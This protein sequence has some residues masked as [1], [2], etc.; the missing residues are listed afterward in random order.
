MK[1]T[2]LTTV[3]HI[4]QCLKNRHSHN[5][6]FFFYTLYILLLFFYNYV[7]LIFHTSSYRFRTCTEMFYVTFNVILQHLLLR[8]L[9]MYIFLFIFLMWD[10]HHIFTFFFFVPNRTMELSLFQE[11]FSSKM[12]EVTLQETSTDRPTPGTLV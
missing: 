6:L 2:F 9:I 11:T 4:F 8:V 12:Q 3:T 1:N 5:S 7:Y 10:T